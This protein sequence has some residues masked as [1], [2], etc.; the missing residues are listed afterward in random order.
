MTGDVVDRKPPKW[1]ARYVIP[2][3]CQEIVARVASH[4]PL[5]AGKIEIKIRRHWKAQ[6]PKKAMS[7]G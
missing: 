4:K 1:R 2:L 6:T 3:V 7:K 5:R